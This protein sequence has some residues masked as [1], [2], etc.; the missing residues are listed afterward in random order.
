LRKKGPHFTFTTEYQ[1]ES[2]QNHEAYQNKKQLHHQT[3]ILEKYEAENSGV[4]SSNEEEK[5]HSEASLSNS[6]SVS[7]KSL[8]VG[9]RDLPKRKAEKCQVQEESQNLKHRQTREIMF[10]GVEEELPDSREES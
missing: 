7:F 2:L 4:L 1:R 3:S 10:S 8:H 5:C 6:S 9:D